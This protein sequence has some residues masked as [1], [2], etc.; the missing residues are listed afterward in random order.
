MR[1]RPAR[2]GL[3]MVLALVVA[4][5]LTGPAVAQD[6]EVTV[7]LWTHEFEPLQ[8][9]MLEKW[10][11]EFEAAHPNITVTMTTIP[12]AGV[13]TYD[14]RLLASLSSGGGPDV[15]DMGDWNYPMFKENG[16][17]EPLDPAVFGYESDQD[18]LDSYQEGS[19]SVLEQDGRLVG[20]FSEFNTLNLF[21]NR[22]LF[23]EIGVE[24][25]PSDRPVSWDEI[26]EIGQ[27]LRVEQDGIL[28]RIGLQLGFFANF[29]NAHWYALHFYQFM[30]QHGQDDIFVDGAPAANT[31]AAVASFQEIADLQYQYQ[32][33]DP[34]FLI[35]WFADVPQGRA[36][37]VLAGTWYPA[38]ALANVPDFDFGVAPNPVL[39]PDDPDTYHNVSWLWAWSVNANSPDPEKAAA[40]EFLAFIL[41]KQGETE[42]AAWWFE[43]LGYFQP[44]RAFI[45]SEAYASALG[46]RPWLELWISAFENYQIDTVQHSFDAA[47][48][49]LVRA[50]DRVIYDGAS[51]QEAADQLQAELERGA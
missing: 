15:W 10:I 14:T 34:T 8:T 21:Y 23:G 37:M 5:N 12:I 29:R 1:T 48:A 17:L 20:L 13:V 27:Q 26:G 46:E 28:E 38:A 50:I 30:R 36:G 47:G 39:D 35:D 40:Q 22:A 41:G 3:S 9:A 31:E 49:A 7:E 2:L 19:T 16:F 43:N 11:P 33:Y 45:E 24:D 6:G 4:A 42:Q 51:A 32:A 18:F 44:S 25:L